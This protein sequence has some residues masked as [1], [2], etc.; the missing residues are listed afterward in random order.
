MIISSKS[1]FKNI[2]FLYLGK[3]IGGIFNVILFI[4][5]SHILLKNDFGLL[6]IFIS[7]SLYVTFLSGLGIAPTY[8]RYVPEYIKD[9]RFV[10]AKNILILGI[11]IRIFA[12]LFFI[13]IIYF[14]LPWFA[15]K[16]NIPEIS[17][18]NVPEGLSEYATLRLLKELGE[19]NWYYVEIG[20]DQVSNE[21]WAK[22]NKKYK[23]MY[24]ALVSI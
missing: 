21:I 7:I 20:F 18:L 12:G 22:L 5:L 3:I 9:K 2:T 16:N 1:L 24:F 14:F 13:G 19:K 17:D 10:A 6:G 4:Y 15:S 23:K 8:L 11:F